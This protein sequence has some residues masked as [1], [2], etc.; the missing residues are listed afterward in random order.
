MLK[1]LRHRFARLVGNSQGE[2][3]TT[4]N[5]VA[6]ACCTIGFMIIL[7]SWA[8]PGGDLFLDN[9][10]RGATLNTGD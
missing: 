3:L 6:S 9:L 4:G 10:I 8:T 2:I 1:L 7:L 5:I